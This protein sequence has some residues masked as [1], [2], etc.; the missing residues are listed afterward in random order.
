[1]VLSRIADLLKK[2]A[3]F[4][5][6]GA[7]AGVRSASRLEKPACSSSGQHIDFPTKVV[8]YSPYSLRRIYKSMKN[9]GLFQK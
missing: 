1:L 2:M 8:K 4:L 7:D 3:I 6:V 5:G 9:Q